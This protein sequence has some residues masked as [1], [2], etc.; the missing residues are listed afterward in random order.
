MPSPLARARVL[1]LLVVLAAPGCSGGGSSA[2]PID[3]PPGSRSLF[4]DGCPRPGFAHA[5]TIDRPDLGAWGPGALGAEGDVVLG[6]DR[7]A[8]VITAPDDDDAYYYYGGI[9]VDAVAVD[10][11]R[12]SGPERFQELEPLLGR[13][14]LDEFTDSTLRG[15]RAESLEIVSD[16][17]NG[18]PAVVRARG[19]DDTYWLVE[20]EI[21]R[22]AIRA[23]APRTPSAAF[24]VDVTIDYTLPADSAVLRIDV[25]ITNRRDRAQGVLPAVANLFGTTMELDPYAFARFSIA[26]FGLEAGSPWLTARSPQ[27]DGAVSFAMEDALL[28]RTN[29]S[30]VDATLDL[31]RALTGLRL[32]AAGSPTESGS[33]RY[34]LSVGGSDGNSAEVPLGEV[35][36]DAYPGVTAELVPVAG[37]VVDGVSQQPVPDAEVTVEVPDS[38]G[39]WRPLHQLRTDATGHFAGSVAR[40]P[41]PS[42]RYRV[43][44]RVE[45]HAPSEP[46]AFDPAALGATPLE[47][48]VGGGGSLAYDVRDGEDRPMPA[49]ITLWR[50]GV[51]AQVIY[52]YPGAGAAPVV[53]GRYEVSVTR[54]YEYQPYQGVVEVPSVGEARLAVTLPRLVDT[55]GFQS[56]DGHMHAEPSPDAPVLLPRRIATAA[57]EGLEVAI[58]TDHEFIGSWQRGIDETGLGAFIATVPGEEL[59]AS[60]PEHIN[61][62]QVEPRPDVNA[63]GGPVRWYG[64]DIDTIF[65]EARQRGAGIVSLNHPRFD[66]AYL[67][68]SGYDRL[69]GLA[70]LADPTILGLAADAKLWS[71]N[72]DVVEYLNG[73]RDPFVDPARPEETG[74]FED[75]Q[76]F[77]NL[78]HRIAAVGV[79]D[80]HG[81]ERP[82]S[83][84]TYF[85]ATS[86]DPARLDADGMV[87][88]LEAGRAI[89]SAG[90]FARVRAASGE[91]L[92]ELA[93]ASAGALEL[94]VHV[95]ALP[96]VDVTHVKVF[97]NCDEVATL[98]AAEPH[99]VVKLDRRVSLTLTR[100][101]HVEVLA[102]G[103]EPMP[104]GLR[105]YDATRVPRVTTNPIYVDVDGNGA[106]D[107]PGG[108]TCTYDLLRTSSA[109]AS[110]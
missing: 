54:G 40:F 102:F 33:V 27:G 107:A 79:T 18:E 29:I 36:P 98:P 38:D 45:G 77:L 84:R 76:S 96:E 70:T 17:S 58:S 95:E 23:G 51:T 94:D 100:D 14:A 49:R 73:L 26:G 8:F 61:L 20:Y 104:R 41:N 53:P 47:L 28:V 60:V 59:T 24:G 30:G 97:A 48:V 105:T 86:D 31:F 52:G 1:A 46:R 16:G 7:A 9:V 93:R 92:G 67:C 108:K 89:V 110:R 99:G 103:R 62:Y 63:R 55:T 90:A 35:R 21:L 65:A 15:F 44:A 80:V 75:W 10:G 19:T 13:L 66:C 50:D 106:F 81:L 39:E 101:A 42:L 37:Q 109:A 6:N 32:G 78:G 11:C 57:S 88:A 4:V 2:S 3:G 43:T 69:T 25:S 34:F 72:F 87:A 12:Q 56:M 64:K 74:L 85:A 83:P 68:L 91:G 71:W 82:G 22:R 5:R